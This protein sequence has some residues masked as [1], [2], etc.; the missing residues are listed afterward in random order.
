MWQMKG[1]MHQ[2]GAVLLMTLLA[3]QLTR[4]Q[5]HTGP[6]DQACRKAPMDV[7]FALDGSISDEAFS[8]VQLLVLNLVNNFDVGPQAT[9]VG[10]VQYADQPQTEFPLDKHATKEALRNAIKQL[11]SIRGHAATGRALRHLVERSFS[12]LEGARPLGLG[13][14]RLIVLLSSGRSIDDAVGPARDVHRAGL[15]LY[16][17]DV[18]G[19]SESLMH[20]IA[21]KPSCVFVHSIG[22]PGRLLPK[23]C[24]GVMCPGKAGKDSAPGVD[25]LESFALDFA[26]GVD[27]SEGSTPGR[28]AFHVQ[29]TAKLTHDLR[30]LLPHGLPTQFSLIVTLQLPGPGPTPEPT[31]TLWRARFDGIRDALALR[32]D[33]TARSIEISSETPSGR[34]ESHVFRGFDSL[35]DGNWHKL[36]LAV[37][38]GRVSLF[39]DCHEEGTEGLEV[40]D[41][42]GGFMDIALGGS[43]EGSAPV[44][45]QPPRFHLE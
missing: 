3:L 20:R 41:G 36:A 8:A 25:L 13:I 44:R 7:V 19:A 45:P 12:S 33:G 27:M 9:R 15:L 39:V 40:I 22:N 31:W 1:G 26:T 30:H 16:T 37:Q 34:S 24:E 23:I 21:S 5:W 42:R 38:D 43:G 4:A 10:L 14:R 32:V 17:V 18:D 29:R 35:F 6:A 2:K 11:R 28:T